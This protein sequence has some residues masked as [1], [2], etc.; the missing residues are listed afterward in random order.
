PALLVDL[1]TQARGLELA[2]RLVA[3]SAGQIRHFDD[4]PTLDPNRRPGGRRSVS[5]RANVDHVRSFTEGNE[6]TEPATPDRRGLAEDDDA[7][8]AGLDPPP[9]L[10]AA[11]VGYRCI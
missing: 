6:G 3:R 4:H 8:A 9:Y 5:E 2:D 11:L 1:C 10:D 7:R